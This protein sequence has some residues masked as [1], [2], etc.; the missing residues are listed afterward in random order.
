[1]R[2]CQSIAAALARRKQDKRGAAA[3]SG[4]NL[5]KRGIEAQR[6]ELQDAGSGCDG[7]AIDLHRRKIG[8]AAMRDGDALGRSGGAGGV[9]DVGGV[10]RMEAGGRGG[11]GLLRDGGPVGIEARRRA[12]RCDARA[13]ARAAPRG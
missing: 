1:M 2:L 4:S 8:D 13:D 10:L 7:E 12:A 6:C 9:D 5:R 3:Q 11:R